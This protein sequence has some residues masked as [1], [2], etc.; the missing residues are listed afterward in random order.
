MRSVPRYILWISLFSDF[1]L[2]V[3]FAKKFKYLMTVGRYLTDL[4]FIED[5]NPNHVKSMPNLI[6][7]DKRLKTAEK[8]REIQEYQRVPYALVEVHEIQ[9]Y[10][11]ECLMNAERDAEILYQKSLVVEPK[12]REDEKIARLL[13]E[14]GFL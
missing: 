1:I 10:I 6:N 7:F 11:E 2:L 12:E 14:S 4:T 5:G 3:T 8:I 13:H 9:Q